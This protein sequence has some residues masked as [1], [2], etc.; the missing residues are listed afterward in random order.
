M[1]C[2]TRRR[3]AAEMNVKII[4]RGCD[5]STYFDMDMT[6]SEFEFLIRLSEKSKAVSESQCQPT[7]EINETNEL[8]PWPRS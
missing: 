1:V 6:S 5:D 8:D 2:T 4:I 3:A 7:I